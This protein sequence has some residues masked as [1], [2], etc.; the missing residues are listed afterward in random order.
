MRPE[1]DPGAQPLL[2][3][4]TQSLGF[5]SMTR[6]SGTATDGIYQ[7]TVSVPTAAASGSWTVT[8]HPLDDTLGNSDATFHSHPTKLT[9]TNAPTGTVPGAPTRTTASAG[10]GRATVSWTAPTS[11]GGSPVTVYT[12]TSTPAGRTCTTTGALSC[13][14]TGL[15]NDTAYTFTVTATNAIGTSPASAAS[16]PVTPRGSG[17]RFTSLTPTRVLDTRTGTGA[18]QAPVG[19][20]GA[21]TL[22]I[23]GLPADTT[24]VTLNLTG[25]GPTRSTYITAWPT[26]TTRPNSSNLNLA[27]GATD[28]NLVTVKVGPGGKVSLYN[29]TAPP[30]SWPTSPATTPPPRPPATTPAPPP[31]CSTPAPAP[32]PP[33]PPLGAGGAITL[34][35]PGLPADT[36]AVTLNLTGTG[37]TRSTYITAWPTGSTRP[38]SSN[39]NLTAGATDANLVTVK[40][41]TGGKVSLYNANGTT[42]LLADLAGYYHPHRDLRLPRGPRT[43]VLDTRTGTGAP[44]APSAPAARS[45]SPSP[46]CPA[47]TTAVTLNLT[48]TGPTATP[49]SPPGPRRHRHDPTP[50]TSTS[51]RAPPTPTSSPSRSDPAARSAS[52]TPTAPPTSWP[53]SPATSPPDHAVAAVAWLVCSP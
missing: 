7:K 38:N 8:I 16:T 21:I 49:T 18:P 41:G 53:T 24:A 48:G 2:G 19:A 17:A 52:T 11:T 4:T 42:H 10:N 31:G 9:V 12:V 51:P 36:T 26:G 43:R 47:G 28:A 44:K 35:I 30:T 46:G 3:D 22:T 6:T 5:G 32:E 25:T 29:A 33:R 39:L 34:T 23:P 50:P 45:P 15:T 27:A 40:V 37:P 20:G 1:P 13:T 14:V